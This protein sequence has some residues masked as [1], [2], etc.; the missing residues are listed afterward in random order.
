MDIF[1]PP[2]FCIARTIFFGAFTFTGAST[3]ENTAHSREDNH[4]EKKWHGLFH[5]ISLSVV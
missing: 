3:K 5:F 1:G 2:F 4:N